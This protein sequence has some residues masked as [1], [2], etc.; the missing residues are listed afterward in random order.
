MCTSGEPQIGWRACGKVDEE[1]APPAEG[2]GQQ[3]AERRPKAHAQANHAVAVAD[4]DRGLLWPGEELDHRE[5]VAAHERLAQALHGTQRN[6]RL[7]GGRKGAAG[8]APDEDQ[9]PDPVHAR[10][11]VAVAQA[12]CGDLS[13]GAQQ[14]VDEHDPLRSVQR[15]RQL[16]CNRDEAHVHHALVDG[17]QE[18]AWHECQNHARC[19]VTR[20]ACLRLRT[21]SCCAR[22]HGRSGQLFS[23]AR[24]QRR[25]GQLHGSVSVAAQHARWNCTLGLGRQ[26]HRTRHGGRQ[27]HRARHG[28]LC[29]GFEHAKVRVKPPW[30]ASRCWVRA[31][32]HLGLAMWHSWGWQLVTAVARRATTGGLVA[33]VDPHPVRALL[34][35]WAEREDQHA[36]ADEPRPSH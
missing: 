6:Q 30:E 31:Q 24:F 10:L 8:G 35:P 21:G 15:R 12:A 34:H 7:D 19:G 25:R 33:L 28:E 4:R 1:D 2:R 13:R 5:R 23:C 20:R 29:K 14:E 16:L 32:H 9:Q 11:A 36:H 27:P 18:R 22:F 17:S 3:P 26:P